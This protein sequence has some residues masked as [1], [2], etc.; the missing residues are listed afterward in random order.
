MSTPWLSPPAV[1]RRGEET[2]TL[3]LPSVSP[4][5]LVEEYKQERRLLEQ[6][7]LLPRRRQRLPRASVTYQYD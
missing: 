2:P 7:K 5:V 6:S 3:V 1:G 4:W